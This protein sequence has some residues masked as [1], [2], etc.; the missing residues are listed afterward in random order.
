MIAWAGLEMY[1][2]GWETD[3]TA[4]PIRKWSLDDDIYVEGEGDSVNNNSTGGVL[5]AAHWKRRARDM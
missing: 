4:L 5:S 2:V 1:R 3:F